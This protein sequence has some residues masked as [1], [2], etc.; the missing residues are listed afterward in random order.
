[1][2]L[3][4]EGPA[5]GPAANRNYA[6]SRATG[7]WLVFT[8]DDCI[9]Q[10]NW[11]SAFA[12]ALR[13]SFE[14]YEGKTTCKAGLRSPLE[15]APANE[16]GGYLWSCNMLIGKALFEWLGG[17]DEGFG[18]PAM[19]DV[20][21]RERLRDRNH[22]ALFVAAAVVD[23]PPRRVR[24]LAELIARHRYFYRFQIVKRNTVPRLLD[25]LIVTAKTRI[26]AFKRPYIQ[27]FPWALCL[28]TAEFIVLFARAPGWRREYKQISNAA[29]A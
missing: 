17:F 8:D 1:M 24:G 21:L 29:A 2:A 15:H 12:V 5:R 28:F 13:P 11:L 3:Y 14:V 6:V 10:E 19:E 26:R 18:A 27:D 23:H 7:A 4:V 16:R 20:D 25:I 22:R 9:P